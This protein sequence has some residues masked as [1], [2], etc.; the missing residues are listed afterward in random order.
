M[1]RGSMTV[2]ITA[3]IGLLA[4]TTVATTSVAALYAARSQATT[5][6][7]SAAL[8]AAVATYPG[9]E[10][11]LPRIEAGVAASRNGARLLACT[12]SVDPSMSAR[13]VEVMVG[14]DV[15]VPI[16]GT[17]V[18]RTPSRAEFDPGVWLG[19]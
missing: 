6:A 1:E 5:A 11:Q 4:A 15:E 13:V 10:R 19:R 8:A 9:T 17:F 12:C 2:V 3:V 14:V 16:F 18:V 7:D